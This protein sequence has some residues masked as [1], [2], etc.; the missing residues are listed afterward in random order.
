MYTSTSEVAYTTI[1]ASPKRTWSVPVPDTFPERTEPP[2]GGARIFGTDVCEELEFTPSFRLDREARIFTIGSCFARNVEEALL[3]HGF[4]VLTR[5]GPFSYAHGYLNRYNTPVMSHEIDLATGRK[6]FADASIANMDS[7]GYADLTAY[8]HF[9]SRDQVVA[10][11]RETTDVFRSILSADFVIITAGL[12]EVWYDKEYDCYTN[13]APS[14]AALVY[15]E[16]YEFR[17]LSYGD[18]LQGLRDLVARIL[19][20][21]PACKIVMTVS[22]VPLNATFVDRDVLISN[23]YSKACLRAAVEEIQWQYPAIDY[24]PSFEMTNLSSPD[25]VW[26]SDRRHVRQSFVD[27]IMAEFIKRYVA[28]E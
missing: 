27:A 2:F 3:G 26:E 21:R 25:V 15:P 20:I 16:R 7:D 23:S 5:Q 18:N 8:G 14:R 4:N 17:L 19:E 13:V 22:P 24:F 1:R 12:S 10:L 6:H 28:E 9:D 11:R